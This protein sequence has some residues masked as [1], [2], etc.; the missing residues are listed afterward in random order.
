MKHI[1]VIRS[2]LKVATVGFCDLPELR[3]Q[4]LEL[5]WRDNENDKSCIPEGTYIVKRDKIGHHQWYA[6]QNV[7]NRE[8]VE[9]HPANWVHELKGCTAFGLTRKND[10]VSVSESKK[11]LLELLDFAGDD[12][13][14]ITY[15][16]FNHHVDRW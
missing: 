2:Y 8:D 6:I 11:A 1:T 9:L 15:R 10:G 7:A 3:L 5:P 12:D 4:T 14:L 13:F 16:S